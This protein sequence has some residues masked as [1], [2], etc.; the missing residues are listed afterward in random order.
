[1]AIDIARD[2][3]ATRGREEDQRPTYVVPPRNAIAPEP[4]VVV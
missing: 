4:G 3:R 2:N 1:M